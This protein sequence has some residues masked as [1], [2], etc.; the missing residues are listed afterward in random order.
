MK[1]IITFYSAAV[2][3]LFV[4]LH[5][6]ADILAGPITNPANGHE[7]YLLSPSTWTMSEVEAENCGG[8]LAII[9]NADEQKW[10]FSTFD[11]DSQVNHRSGL[12]IGLHRTKPGGSFVWV[13]GAKLDY[14]NWNQG[15]PNNVGGIENCVHMT[16]GGSSAAGTWNDLPDNSSI[17]FGVVELLGKA[18]E[19]PLS[20]AERALIGNWYE[21]GKMERPCWIAGTDNTLFV[22]QN[23]KFASRASLSADGALLVSNFQN[24]W[25]M[26]SRVFDGYAPYGSPQRGMRGEVIKDKILWSNGTWWSQ[27]PVEY[28]KD[29]K[30]SDKEDVRAKSTDAQK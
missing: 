18:N 20:S 2:I 9:K 24:G 16:S 1:K 15:E 25:P 5:T 6:R 7:Y 22:I 26:G 23:N 4:T 29:E 12:W 3:L 30:S 17:M 13:T 27:K 14:T 8:T 19:I 28:G 10:V 11:S 21:G